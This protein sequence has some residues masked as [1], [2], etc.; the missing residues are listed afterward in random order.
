MMLNGSMILDLLGRKPRRYILRTMAH[1]GMK[2]ADGAEVLNY[3]GWWVEVGRT[4]KSYF[5]AGITLST[6]KDA[7]DGFNCG[8]RLSEMF[9]GLK[10]PTTLRDNQVS[11]DLNVCEKENPTHG[12]VEIIMGG[13]AAS[14]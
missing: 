10:L 1:Y 9:L 7:G 14:P 13:Q 6:T 12:C 4:P 2:E 11:P 5:P 3:S 8:F